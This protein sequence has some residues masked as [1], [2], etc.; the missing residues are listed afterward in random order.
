[1]SILVTGA[2]GFVG[3]NTVEQ[4][5]RQGEEVVAM[6]DR[7]LPPVAAYAFAELPGRLVSIV[8][9]IRHH[10]GLCRILREY[11]VTHVLHAA[12]VTSNVERERTQSCLVV[13]VNLSG[14]T[15]VATASAAHGVERF[16]FVSSNAIFG[17]DTPDY[18]ML[19]ED[20]PKA[21][22]NL[23]A[24]TKWTGEMILDKLGAATGLDWVAGRLAGVFGPWEYRTGIRDTMNPVFQANGLA[25]AGRAAFLPRPGRSNWHF[26][27]DA[28]SSLV[29]LLTAPSHRHRI[30]NLGTPFVWSIGDWCARLAERFPSFRIAI[31][32][33]KGDATE[34]DLYGGHDGGILSWQRFSEEFG[35]TGLCDLDAAFDHLMNWHAAHQSFGLEGSTA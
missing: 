1:M 25:H 33:H 7:A 15:A 14:L 9:D 29:T 6:A 11:R 26:S 35:P 12:A 18:A 27:R 5:L 20:W 24:L 8:A 19:D 16:V 32:G 13:S 10:E 22:G 4:L 17:G 23:Y 28:A 30:Y 2:S 34:I 21:P 3:L 31:G